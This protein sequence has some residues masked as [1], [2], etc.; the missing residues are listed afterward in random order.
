MESLPARRVP[1]VR[2]VSGSLRWLVPM[3]PMIPMIASAFDSLVGTL[4][5]TS[6]GGFALRVAQ[7]S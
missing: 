2:P 1:P 4:V 6:E 7:L 5:E 3:I